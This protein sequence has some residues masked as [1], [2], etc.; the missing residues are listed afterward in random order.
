MH[1]A[2][3]RH[4]H[5]L[6]RLRSRGPARVDHSGAAVRE[7]S[8]AHGGAT[9]HE[10]LHLPVPR[11]PQLS[12][13][14]GSVDRGS[15]GFAAPHH[16]AIAERCA[17]LSKANWDCTR[18][19][20]RAAASFSRPRSRK[21]DGSRRASASNARRCSRRSR[22]VSQRSATKSTKRVIDSGGTRRGWW[23]EA[24]GA[25]TATVFMAAPG[26]ESND[27]LQCWSP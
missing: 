24:T 26:C 16:G 2:R 25:G 22:H 27:E 6:V 3:A 17:L 9:G 7:R 12:D 4:G 10:G 5:H 15:G 13:S 14:R 21:V 18:A 20:A 8:P 11:Q 23:H 19:S 1:N